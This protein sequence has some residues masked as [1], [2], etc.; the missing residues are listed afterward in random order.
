M[1]VIVVAAYCAHCKLPLL[2]DV[3]T[4]ETANRSRAAVRNERLSI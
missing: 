1:H 4:R 3:T 2:I